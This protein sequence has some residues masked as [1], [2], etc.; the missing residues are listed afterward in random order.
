MRKILISLLL[1]VTVC[2]TAQEYVGY[3]PL[4][5][6]VDCV[7]TTTAGDIRRVGSKLNVPFYPKQTPVGIAY[8]SIPI[9][10]EVMIDIDS[11]D[12]YPIFDFYILKSLDGVIWDTIASPKYTK[13][14]IGARINLD[15]TVSFSEIR[16]TQIWPTIRMRDSIMSLQIKESILFNYSD[17]P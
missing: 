15:T 8:L 16:A 9:D 6:N 4:K 5:V 7:Y 3:Y 10:I 1:F 11:L 14:N 13:N 2:I 12:G 17:I